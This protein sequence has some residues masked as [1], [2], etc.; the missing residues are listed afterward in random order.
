MTA[1]FYINYFLVIFY[2][3]IFNFFIL[4]NFVKDSHLDKV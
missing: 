4:L 3:I 1:F 2:T